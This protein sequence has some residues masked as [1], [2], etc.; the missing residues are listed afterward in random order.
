MTE[1]AAKSESFDHVYTTN[2]SIDAVW[3]LTCSGM[4]MLM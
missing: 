1:G 3:R 4:I 2:Q